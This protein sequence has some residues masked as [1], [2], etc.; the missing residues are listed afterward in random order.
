MTTQVSENVTAVLVGFNDYDDDQF[1]LE[2]TLE[3]TA[4]WYRLLQRMGVPGRNVA[5]LTNRDAADTAAAL[6]FTGRGDGDPFLYRVRNPDELFDALEAFGKRGFAG[7]GPH[8]LLLAWSGHG[9]VVKNGGTTEPVLYLPDGASVPVFS[10][11]AVTRQVLQMPVEEGFT[12]GDIPRMVAFINAC[13]A[14]TPATVKGSI[15]KTVRSRG[16]Q[17]PQKRSA[18]GRMHTIDELGIVAFAASADGEPAAR[19][20]QIDGRWRGA[21][22]WA[23]TSV[24]SRYEVK[25]GRVGISY[26]EL[27]LRTCQMLDAIGIEARPLMFAPTGETNRHVLRGFGD[28]EFGPGTPLAGN[29]LEVYPGLEGKVA[30]YT[31]QVGGKVFGLYITGKKLDPK[32]DWGDWEEDRNYWSWDDF[33][34]DATIEAAT[35]FTLIPKPGN[36]PSG[37]TEYATAPWPTT[38][39]PGTVTGPY[40]RIEDA[41]GTVLGAMRVEGGDLAFYAYDRPSTGNFFA[42]GQKSNWFAVPY[43]GKYTYR[44]KVV[45]PKK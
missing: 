38:Q 19:E 36:K 34:A 39:T 41:A 12:P 24:L 5:I 40:L 4:S 17:E 3:D 32:D 26:A 22:P 20:V 8:R 13:D 33:D 16:Y 25:N 44:Y 35:P 7:Q 45:D 23:V 1:D 29:T 11:L 30:H 37:L 28:L 21:M 31:V 2:G 15:S 43:T 10:F 9:A 14:G 18:R 6:G 42:V 27:Y